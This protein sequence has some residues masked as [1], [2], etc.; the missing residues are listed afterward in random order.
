MPYWL[1]LPVSQSVSQCCSILRNDD[2]LHL[3]RVISHF[4]S[5]L[6][7]N[8]TEDNYVILEKSLTLQ[9]FSVTFFSLSLVASLT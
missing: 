7:L 9:D 8:V 1:K 2:I 3:F 5:I 4:T 6:G